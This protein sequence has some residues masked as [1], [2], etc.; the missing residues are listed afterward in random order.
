MLV[1]LKSRDSDCFK[2]TSS[3]EF[4]WFEQRFWQPKLTWAVLLTIFFIQYISVHLTICWQF[5]S[6]GHF[7]SFDNFC[8]L[9]FFS[10]DN[11]CPLDNFFS[12]DN[13]VTWQVC[14]QDI[15]CDN[16]V[17]WQFCPLDIFLFSWKFMSTVSTC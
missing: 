8:P 11:F 1:N 3:R 9:D 5:L 13:F 15:F 16:F 6:T 14:Q 2:L 10:F 12:L 4:D 7:C 17:T